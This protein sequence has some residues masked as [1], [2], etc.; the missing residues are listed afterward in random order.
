MPTTPAHRLRLRR[1]LTWLVGVAAAGGLLAACGSSDPPAPPASLGVV[2]DRPV[3]TVPLVDEA[4]RA[5]S[6]AS[7]RGK[8]VVLAPFLTL[9]QD[10][11]PLVTGAFIALQADVAA[12]G[13]G[14]SVVFLGVSVDPW[15]DTPARLSAYSRRFG[16]DWPLWTGTQAQLTRFWRFFGVYFAQA[17]EDQPAH[18]DWLTGAPLT[19]DVDH[20]DGF[21][22]LDRRGHER[23]LTAAPPNLH[24]KLSPALEALLNDQGRHNLAHPPSSAWT[25]AQAAAAIGWLVGKDVA[26]PAG[27]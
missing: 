23:F 21:I 18:D 14:H 7:L 11:C 19:F 1:A 8:D 5:V 6:L 15:R 16:A 25:V 2:L 24:G 17:P 26:P 10:E 27:S 4:G 9:C 13:L 3:P 12:A 22:L 20:T